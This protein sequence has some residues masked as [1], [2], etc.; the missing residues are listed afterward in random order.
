[1]MV[2]RRSSARVAMLLIGLVVFIV[3]VV[4]GAV[5]AVGFLTTVKTLAPTVVAAAI[6]PI[7]AAAITPIVTAIVPAVTVTPLP[8]FAAVITFFFLLEFIKFVMMEGEGADVALFIF[9]LLVQALFELTVFLETVLLGHLG[10]LLVSLDDATFASES[11]Q[12]ALEDGVF[13]KLA[14]Q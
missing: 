8:Q 4:F 2:V 5:F 1:M 12:L 11:F 7:V 10:F 13:A 9:R 6:T 14:F 3:P